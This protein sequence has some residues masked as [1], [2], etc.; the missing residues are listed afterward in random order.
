MSTTCR[1]CIEQLSPPSGGWWRVM[2]GARP[3]RG[4]DL[5]PLQ[6]RGLSCRMM[7]TSFFMAHESL[8]MEGAPLVPLSARQAVYAAAAQRPAGAGS[9]RDPAQPGDRA[10]IPGGYLMAGA[11][12]K[13]MARKE[14]TASSFIAERLS[15]ARDLEPPG[16][17]A[18]L[19]GS[20]RSAAS[21]TQTG[22]DQGN[23][24]R[25]P[26]KLGPR[27][28]ARASSACQG[29]APSIATQPV[30]P[31]RC[32]RWPMPWRQASRWEFDIA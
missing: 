7:E 2:A 23:G 11:G 29:Y 22:A 6:R 3:Q 28:G 26:G 13:V 8:I 5:P 12:P 31:V 17:V 27:D 16:D 18:P 19:T 24:D 9:V 4:G 32:T 30:A 14:A 25:G 20:Q 10:G 1:V 21:G 15:S